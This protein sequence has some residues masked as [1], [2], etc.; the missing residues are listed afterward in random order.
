MFVGGSLKFFF[1]ILK[2]ECKIEKLQLNCD[3]RYGPCLALYLIITWRILYLTLLS[4]FEPDKSCEL[5]FSTI[6]WQTIY[7]ISKKE[8]PPSLATILLMVAKMGGFLNRKKDKNPGPTAIWIG[9][10]RLKDFTLAASS[11]K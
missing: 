8:K 11:F 4:R 3:K 2:N 9:L 6:E 7:Q 5:F 10:Q 1:R